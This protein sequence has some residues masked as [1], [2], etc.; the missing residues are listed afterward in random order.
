MPRY[1]E[2]ES[3]S[4][5]RRA[6]RHASSAL[7]PRRYW[8]ERG[9]PAVDEFQNVAAGVFVENA[10][11]ADGHGDAIR[12]DKPW[13]DCISSSEEYL[14]V[15]TIRRERSVYGPMVSGGMAGAGREGLAGLRGINGVFGKGMFR[16]CHDALSS[17]DHHDDFNFV[18]GLEG[19]FFVVTPGHDLPI[20]F[21]GI[22]GRFEM[23][24][25]LP[26]VHQRRHGGRWRNV[27]RLA[28]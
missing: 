17:A 26:H 15:P 5:P 23:P 4:R 14:P 18:A 3:N 10:L 9:A 27:K 12:A 25:V 19:R 8:G 11:A 21:H 6:T 16:Q 13:Q 24:G 2:W 22:S 7:K 20:A 28:I 1:S